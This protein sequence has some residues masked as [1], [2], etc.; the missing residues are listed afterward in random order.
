[1]LDLSIVIV[2][3]NARGLLRQCLRSL[4]ENVQGS[5]LTWKIVLVDNNSSD[6][7]IAMV[8]EQFADVR[9]IPL[10]ENGGYAKG[11]NVGIRSLEARYY[12]ILNMDTTIVQPHAIERMVSYMEAHPDVGLAGPKLINPNGTTQASSCIF[13]RFWYPLY[14]R[15]FVGKLRFAKKA[16]HQYLMLD[17][18]HDDTRPVDWVIGTGMMVRND[19]IQHVGLMD[20]RFF[21]Y[22]ED[23]DWCRR[24]WEHEWKVVYIADVE[25]V[26]YHGRE[27]AK[28]SGMV[29]VIVSKQTRIHVSSWIKY[30]L[31]YSGKEPVHAKK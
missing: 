7:S 25:I 20:E 8:R 14:R 19:A 12:L 31:K 22:F 17:W 11:V 5:S 27:S 6:D 23:V 2:N 16:I 15:T 1:M 24:F 4:L 30:F 29:S 9:L 28:Q 10:E 26:H 18:D 3:Y 21:M 13:P